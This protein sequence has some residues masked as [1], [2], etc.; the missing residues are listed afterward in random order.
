[1]VL[2]HVELVSRAGACLRLRGELGWGLGL[3][4]GLSAAYGVNAFPRSFRFGY[5]RATIGA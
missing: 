5:H 4:S 2:P 3:W 1:M